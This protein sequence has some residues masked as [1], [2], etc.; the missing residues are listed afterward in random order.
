MSAMST[1]IFYT[2][3]AMFVHLIN[4]SEVNFGIICIPMFNRV[5]KI[6]VPV[7]PLNVEPSYV[8]LLKMF[9]PLFL[10]TD[11]PLKTK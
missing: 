2:V 11:R 10:E 6:G 9:D 3:V 1:C 5:D 8:R 7:Y 4:F